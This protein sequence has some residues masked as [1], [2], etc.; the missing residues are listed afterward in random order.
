MFSELYL[1]KIES[2]TK[3]E[4]QAKVLS[5]LYKLGIDAPYDFNKEDSVWI[6]FYS[7]YKTLTEYKNDVTISSIKDSLKEW[8]K[9]YLFISKKEN[10]SQKLTPYLH[11]FVFHYIEMLALHGNIHKFLTQPNEKLNDFFTQYYHK[12]TNKPFLNYQFIFQIMKKR[13]L[14]MKV[15][16]KVTKKVI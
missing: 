10:F 1:P 3:N 2:F 9:D 16:I 12:S 5:S 6:G 8:I 7:L 4:L 13:N 11:S 15:T 14:T